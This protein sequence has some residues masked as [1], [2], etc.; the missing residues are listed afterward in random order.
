[1]CV[2]IAVAG[3]L[4]GVFVGDWLFVFPLCGFSLSLFY[5]YRGDVHTC[6]HIPFHGDLDVQKYSALGCDAMLKAYRSQK[7]GT[8]RSPR[9][10]IAQRPALRADARHRTTRKTRM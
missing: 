2:R 3:W 6:F 4:H 7:T 10:R 9:I 8:G 1:M 5:N